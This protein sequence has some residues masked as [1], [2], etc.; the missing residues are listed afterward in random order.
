[1]MA[2]GSRP[3]KM[4][5]EFGKGFK[6]TPIW[7]SGEITKCGGTECTSG[8]TETSMKASGPDH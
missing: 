7:A 4:A 3:A 8:A 2:S 1:M 6:M 5:L